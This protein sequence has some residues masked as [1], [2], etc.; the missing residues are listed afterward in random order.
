MDAND[1]SGNHVIRTYALVTSGGKT[2]AAAKTT[3][4]K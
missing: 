2:T 1:I 3:K 4:K